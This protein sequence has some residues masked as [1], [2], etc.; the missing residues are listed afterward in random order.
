MAECGHLNVIHRG[1]YTRYECG[2]RSTEL[3]NTLGCT[4]ELC[5]DHPANV[6]VRVKE[7]KTM[8][9]QAA[10]WD[11]WAQAA[12]DEAPEGVTLR[13]WLANQINVGT[14][15]GDLERL[16]GIA[17]GNILYATRDLRT[18]KV[19]RKRRGGTSPPAPSPPV[20][21]GTETSRATTPGA[22]VPDPHGIEDTD[23][24]GEHP[25][26]QPVG[27]AAPRAQNVAPATGLAEEFIRLAGMGERFGRFC[28][29]V[30]G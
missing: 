25:E 29:A 22:Q 30:M 28:E 16:T 4:P 14:N 20:E 1:G 26:Q 2:F 24:C 9:E 27:E 13:Q 3:R 12:C 15:V 19:T 17:R 7:R 23:R 10:D 5:R 18:N 21:R 11:G 6:A 8:T